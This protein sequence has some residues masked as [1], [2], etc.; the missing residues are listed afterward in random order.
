MEL[1][2]SM[3]QAFSTL[4]NKLIK[5]TDFMII[6]NEEIIFNNKKYTKNDNTWKEEDGEIYNL[7][8]IFSKIG[9]NDNNDKLKLLESENLLLK[10]QIEELLNEEKIIKKK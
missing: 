7:S 6:T 8:S 9:I 4:Q 1:N 10:R 3:K 5:E 2:K